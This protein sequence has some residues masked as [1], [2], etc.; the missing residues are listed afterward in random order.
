MTTLI[1]GKRTAE[2]IRRELGAAV[3]ELR[4]QSGVT[5]GLAVVLVGEDPASIVYTRNKARAAKGCGM[6]DDLFR[7]PADTPEAELLA[8]IERLNQDENVDGILVQL[9]LPGTID[10][11]RVIAAISPEKDADGFHPLNVGRLHLGLA[12][13]IPCTPLGVTVLLDR[14]DIALSGK[15]AVILGRSNI[16][17]KPMAALLTARHATV[18]I[19]HSRTRDLADHCRR[20]DLL[21]SAMG[22]PRVITADMVREGAVVVDVGINRLDDGRL[23]GDVDFDQVAPRTSAITPVP[24]GVGPMTIAMLLTNVFELATRRRRGL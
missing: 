20:A 13:P 9:P 18:T 14:Y 5:P 3:D 4:R 17:G 8:L 21:V 16:V 24:G 12:A 22:R 6:R 19:C 15:E 11:D 2:E 23:V 10:E 1:D 7:L